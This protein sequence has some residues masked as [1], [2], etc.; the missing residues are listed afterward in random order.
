MPECI[1]V[2]IMIVPTEAS[3]GLVRSLLS[4]VADQRHVLGIHQQI[5]LFAAGEVP[6]L[7]DDGERHVAPQMTLALKYFMASGNKY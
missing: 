1:A 2:T 6:E 3:F 7:F 4:G 5:Y